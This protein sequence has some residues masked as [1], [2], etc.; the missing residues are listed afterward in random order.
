MRVSIVSRVFAPE[1]AAAAFRLDALANEFA[2]R[3]HGV[4]VVTSNLPTRQRTTSPVDSVT[5]RR[6]PVLRDRSG[7]VRGYL[8][9][10]SYDVPAFVRL[11]LLRRPDVYV[12]EPPPTTGAVVRVASALR[13]R[14]YVY[15]AA[16]VVSDA[17]EGAGSP[18]TVVRA[19]R[20]LEQWSWGGARHVLAVSDGIKARLIALGVDA[21]RITVVGNGVDISVFR[22][23]GAQVVRAQ[24]YLLYAGTASEVHGAHVF[25]D[26]LAH[27]PSASLVFL[28]GGAE[29]DSLK[30]RAEVIAPGRVTFLPSVSPHEAAEWFRGAAV[31]LASVRP[32]GNYDFAFPTKLYAASACGSPI[33]FSGPGPGRHYAEAAPLGRSTDADPKLVAHA[34]REMLEQGAT[35][36]DR[37]R[38][39]G[40]AND[41]ASLAAVARRGV[42]AVEAL[43][44]VSQ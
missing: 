35:T 38:Q 43:G 16:D 5:V 6:A 15:F 11:L 31:S 29:F 7:A 24:P 21:G 13:N 23:D 8:P 44:L 26:A 37:A 2:R 22:P 25:V 36:D 19:V 20:R 33:F 34:L 17:A 28:G 41:H 40:W 18:A 30:Q 14:P 4:E 32:G 27:L 42:D 10:L 1:P 39:A 3:G 12:A 9:Y